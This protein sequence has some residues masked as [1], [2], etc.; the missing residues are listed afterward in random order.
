[1][2]YG[3]LALA[4]DQLQ[5]AGRVIIKA[6]LDSLGIFEKEVDIATSE[7]EAKKFIE[8]STVAPKWAKELA[9]ESS[10]RFD[11]NELH[12]AKIS[13]LLEMLSPSSFTPPPHTH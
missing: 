2:E 11:W 8:D 9:R 5:I 12:R 13:R 3:R 10:Y 7:E 6:H 4:S 1:M